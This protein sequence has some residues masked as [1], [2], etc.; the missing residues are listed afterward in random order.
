[1]LARP[2]SGAAAAA[3]SAALPNVSDAQHEHDQEVGRA[4]HAVL[5]AH[6]GAR[7]SEIG[8]WTTA[9]ASARAIESHHIT[10]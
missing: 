8:R 5:G 10:S 9:A 1:M 6:A 2:L 4:A 3:C 7:R